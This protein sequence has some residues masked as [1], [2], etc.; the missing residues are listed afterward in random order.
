MSSTRV[1]AEAVYLARVRVRVRGRGR[2]VEEGGGR[3]GV[4]V[5]LLGDRGGT[6]RLQCLHPRGGVQ[7]GTHHAPRSEQ[8]DQAEEELGL[9]LGLGLGSGLGFGVS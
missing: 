6:R 8:C 3:G 9:G 2:Y 5:E 7:H 4:P 1:E